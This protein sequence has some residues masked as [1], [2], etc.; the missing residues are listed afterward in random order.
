M[1]FSHIFG[2]GYRIG[3]T[4]VTIHAFAS[5]DVKHWVDA[6]I[7]DV[8]NENP[9]V[10][11]KSMANAVALMSVSVDVRDTRIVSNQLLVAQR[12]N[13]DANVCVY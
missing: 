13:G 6:R 4:N 8:E 12:S 10:C 7:K 9:I 5:I 2:V 3:D 1:E 11:H